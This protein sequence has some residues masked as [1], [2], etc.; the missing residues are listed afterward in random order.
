MRTPGRQG[1]QRLLWD[2]TPQR[3]QEIRE[4]V[5]DPDNP[6]A[7]KFAWRP[8]TAHEDSPD[9]Q[10]RLWQQDSTEWVIVPKGAYVV[11]HPAGGWT[12]SVP[13]GV[14]A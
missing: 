8:E 13:K 4:L 12:V 1:S 10:A 9:T 11:P 2:G 14:E 5:A 3:A 6:D 7:P